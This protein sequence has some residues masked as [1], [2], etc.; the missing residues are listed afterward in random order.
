MAFVGTA[1]CDSAKRREL[2][3]V[4][5]RPAELAVI[6]ETILAVAE[7]RGG[8]VVV[9][10]PPGI[11]KTRLLA[12]FADRAQTH[13]IRTLFG[14]GFE[15]QQS[16]PFYP[17]FMA[18]LQAD[19]PVGDAK[20]LR[21]MRQSADLR[22]WVVHDLR[23]AIAEAA[24]RQPLIIMLDDIHWADNATLLAL[25]T[26]PMQLQASVVWVFTA[27]S[28]S[29]GA[30]VRDLIS[31]L[32]CAGAAF[33]PLAPLSA[34]A[35][36]DVVQDAVRARADQSLL[37][38]A[39]K[40]HGS[41]FLLTEL[42]RGLDEEGRLNVEGGQASA[43]GD[44]LP[45]RLAVG[46][47][48]RLEGLSA[49]A[50]EVVRVAATLPDRFSAA[51]LAT[52]LDRPA[53]ALVSAV[54]EAVRAD[55]LTECGDQLTFRHG[56]LREATRE[57]IPRSLRRAMERQ[58]AA[59]MLEMGAA[60][61][62]VA[63]QLARSAE[64]G[65]QSAITALRQ[66]V[67]VVGQSDPSTAADLSGRALELLLPGDPARGPLVADTVV[68]LNRANRYRQAQQL[69]E[70]VLLTEVSQES[71]A[72]I[73][74]RVAAG[75]EEPG[76]RIA[77]NRRALQ[78][79]DINDTT[80]ARHLAW[81]AYFEVVNGLHADQ[82]AATTAMV[83]ATSTGDLE[84]RIVSGTAL[85]VLDEQQ[86]YVMRAT[87]RM[88]DVDALMGTGPAT[89]GHIIAVVHRVR[90]FVTVGRLNQAREQV[91]AA[92]AQ[93]RRDHNAMALPPLTILDA[94]VRIAAGELAAARVSI[95]ALPSSEWGTV[96][97][98]N[99]M[100]TMVLTEIA[101][102]TDDR[103][104]LQQMKNDA[105]ELYASTS[106]LVSCGAAYVMA[107]A[108]WHR[109]DTHEAVRWL[110]GQHTRVIT[111]LWLNV[112]EQ[113]ILMS[114]VASAAGD[115]GLRARVL[116]SVEVLE[117]ERRGARLFAAVARHVRGVL[118][119]D[120]DAL[121]DAANMLR[122]WRPL[123]CAG[124]GEDAGKELARAGRIDEAIEQL[125]DAFDTFVD[126][127]A[128]ADARRVGR[129]LRALGVE[130]RIVASPRDKTGWDSLTDAE[131]KIVNMIGDGATNREVAARLN[132]SPHTVKAHVRNAFTKLGIRSR[133]ELRR[134]A[135][136]PVA[137]RNP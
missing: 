117:R 45:R 33:I 49:E 109:D 53:T 51:V 56:L 132:L 134:P 82:S 28:G 121:M 60:P 43:V 63:T 127:E 21:G 59:T 123:L 114:R 85:A 124:A 4:R 83:A 3:P 96:T 32:C 10:G 104:T 105:L 55:L 133:A 36:A 89:L 91:T 72:E 125:N 94:M 79:S 42:V 30:P 16:A 25:H 20:A 73:R 9:D 8:V 99:M 81:L 131:L 22:Y 41:P 44:W 19:P 135:A 69:A 77:D 93:A 100:R 112:F 40:A 106:P 31:E 115:A 17:L 23:A 14:R 54:Q 111:P 67:S 50:A 62:E 47:E 102:R 128:D 11:G 15:Y 118:E 18:T 86:G 136:D 98:N 70:S 26:L 71:E 5:G 129:V 95:D 24:S 108:A 107:R 92:T 84:A 87:Q 130:R 120:P 90:L 39:A 126:C 13:G 29:G 61:E 46:M 75:N 119:R 76:Q 101:V 58:S 52:I 38:L 1:A 68:L 78:L 116:E 64:V 88:A 35:V 57:S 122:E 66:A 27:R 110:S 7:G 80:R 48:Q 65:D 137:I 97:E 37:M 113:L 103:K 6:D 34:E 12:E 2:P 74:L